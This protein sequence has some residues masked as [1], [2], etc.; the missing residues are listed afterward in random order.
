MGD[1]VGDLGFARRAIDGLG[2]ALD[3]VA[4]AVELGAHAALPEGMERAALAVAGAGG[5]ALGHDGEGATE[6]GEAA[7]F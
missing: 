3:G 2:G 4:H 6:A 1:K 5:E 7:V